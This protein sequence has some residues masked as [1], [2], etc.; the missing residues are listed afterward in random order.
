SDVTETPHVVVRQARA[1]RGTA[2]FRLRCDPRF[3]YGRTAHTVTLIPG[4]GAV[5]ESVTG[6]L[7]LRTSLPLRV[8]GTAVHAEFDLANGETADIVLEWNAT[9]RPLVTGEADALFTRTVNYW[10][11]WIRRGRYHGRWRE[12]VVRSALVLKLLVYRPTG[13]L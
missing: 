6:T 13:A 5:F 3:D 4:S 7:V 8:E 9:I 11:S 2:S 12:M 1:V 10:Q